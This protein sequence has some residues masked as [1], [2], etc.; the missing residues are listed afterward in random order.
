MV[1]EKVIYITGDT[2]GN[3]DRISRF[4]EKMQTTIDDV[5]IILG[6]AGL[7]YYVNDGKDNKRAIQL[8][9]SVA[10]IPLTLFCIH[11]N[12][13]ERPFNVSGYEEQEHFGS[14][15]YVN[16]NYPNQI[17]AKDGEIYTLS[18]YKA[19]VIGGAYSV[20][21][22]YRLLKGANWFESEQPTSDIKAY[23]EQTC[24]ANNWQVDVVLSHTC[25]V[26]AE[27]RHL[28]LP[29]IDQDSVDK[30]TEVWLQTI[31]DKLIFKKWYFGHFHDDWVNGK[32]EMLF[33]SIEEFT[34]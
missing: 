3:F 29:F 11:G 20:D 27:P 10:A 14:I 25:P 7:N 4:A 17:F 12:H 5:M 23:V 6:D 18:N 1:A 16:P 34:I 26:D 24:E 32:Y 21:K 22:H 28:F 31:A 30:S 33:Q 2:H 15:T 8:K 9:E 13:E 19:L